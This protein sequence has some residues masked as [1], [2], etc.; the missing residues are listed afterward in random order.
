MMLPDSVTD[1]YLEGMKEYGKDIGTCDTALY[2]VTGTTIF[3]LFFATG[4]QPMMEGNT[5]SF[6]LSIAQFYRCGMT[7]VVDQTNVSLHLFVPTY[8]MFNIPIFIKGRRVY[9]HRVVVESQSRSKESILVKCGWMPHHQRSKRADE[10][11]PD[12]QEDE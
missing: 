5:A 3:F 1:V 2:Y 4:C 10:L 8:R 7:K 11:S 12:F 9:Y 6:R